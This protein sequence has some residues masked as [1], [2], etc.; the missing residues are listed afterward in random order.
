MLTI[1]LIFSFSAIFCQQDKHTD[2]ALTKG[3]KETN[4]WRHS[5]GSSLFLLGNLDTEEPPLY[6]QFNYGYNLTSKDVIIAEA[7]TWAYYHPLGIQS[8][9]S[10]EDLYPGK[11]RSFGI[12]LGYQRFHWKGLYSTV[13]ATPF[14]QNFY[15]INDKKIQSGFQLWCQFRVG[16]RFEFFKKRWYLEPST[17]IHYWPINTNFPESFKA[18]ENEWSNYYLFEP[19]LHF[20]FKF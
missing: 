4:E 9:E 7:I 2:S 6:L 8:W 12:G 18:I 14:Y 3:E 10:S 1:A 17:V 19:G 5:I 16:Y 11:I 15:D 20:G 13:Q